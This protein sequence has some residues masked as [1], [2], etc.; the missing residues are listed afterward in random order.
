MS[1]VAGRLEKVEK[2]LQ[3]CQNGLD[4]V[5]KKL[6]NRKDSLPPSEVTRLHSLSVQLGAEVVDCE[7]QIDQL[8][9]ENR[10]S[11]ALSVLIFVIV[12]FLYCVYKSITILA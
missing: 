8:R 5:S 4:E 7:Q 9:R 2:N 3:E 6:R 10:K 1:T 11:M 12:V